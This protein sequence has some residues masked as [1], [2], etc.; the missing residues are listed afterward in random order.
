MSWF[1]RVHRQLE[2]H[3]VVKSM[4]VQDSL[5]SKHGAVDHTQES[6]V[7]SLYPDYMADWWRQALKT[8]AG[9]A[10]IVRSDRRRLVVKPLCI[11]SD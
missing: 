6:R 10:I 4:R 2:I 5:R 7:Y 8:K 11:W 3:F 9:I 1:T